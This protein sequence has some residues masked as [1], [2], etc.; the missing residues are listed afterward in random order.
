MGQQIT[1]F[2]EMFFSVNG[3]YLCED[4][5]TSFWKKYGEGYKSP[6]PYIEVS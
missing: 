1:T 6:G 3:I 5:H 2:E 4:L